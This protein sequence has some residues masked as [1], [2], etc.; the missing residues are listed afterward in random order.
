MYYD[1]IK[2]SV[3]VYFKEGTFRS[4][5]RNYIVGPGAMAKA[6]I[7]SK[8]RTAKSRAGRSTPAKRRTTKT[9]SKATTTRKASNSHVSV[10][11][12]HGMGSQRRHEELSRLVDSL[13]IF[14]DDLPRIRGGPNEMLRA[15]KPCIEPSRVP[16]AGDVTYV[17]L[18]YI[19]LTGAGAPSGDFRFYEAY[20][21][22]V[23][24]DYSAWWQVF[25][26]M[27]RRVF[28]PVQTAFSRWRD[29]Q[30]LR[31]AALLGL[32]DRRRGWPEGCATSD[33]KQLLDAYHDFEGP[34]ARRDY[35]RGRFRDFIAFLEARHKSDPDRLA[36]LHLLAKK[37]RRAYASSE[38]SNAFFLFTLALG[39]VMGIAV[40]AGLVMLLL[41]SISPLPIVEKLVGEGFG[42]LANF[43]EPTWTNVFSLLVSLAGLLGLTRFLSKYMGDVELWTTYEETNTKHKNRREVIKLGAG[44]LRHVL[45]DPECR[46]VV[47][48][49]HSLGTSVAQD[50]LL[51]LTR[52]NLA[53]NKSNPIAGPIPLEK[54]RHFVTL[55]SPI[56]KVQYFFES[57]TS[58]HHRYNRVVEELRGDIGGP[59]F[60]KNG[61]PHIHWVNYWDR[62]D[63]IS[64]SLESPSNSEKSTLRVDN[65]HT[66]N[67][68]F[69]DPGASHSAYFQNRRVIGHLFDMIFRNKYSFANVPR[70]AR[71]APICSRAFIGP[72]VYHARP[73]YLLALATTLPYLALFCALPT[74][75]PVLAGL[76]PILPV[77]SQWA[78]L[79]AS[80]SF[81]ILV[82][83]SVF[84]G[85]GYL[86]GR[87]LGHRDPL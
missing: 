29:R 12:F 80:W 54:I 35:P 28:R 25:K 15:I 55:A 86:A 62:A 42:A 19:N 51:S 84:L 59:P 79:I 50:C 83:V 18:R 8:R 10:V 14:T 68:Y 2:N 61:K 76:I 11:Y 44:V 3:G 60:A 40:S 33:F 30:R 31:R 52:H 78:D 39:L 67:L 24:A 23:M 82:A 27:W 85:L 37:W 56:D 4:K 64:G 43:V 9:K 16:K 46:R 58:D 49:S 87:S 21:A 66:S 34:E 73:I 1:P 53:R 74:I 41:E 17:E 72:G 6:A 45:E 77:T 65:V 38:T 71:R 20:W 47:V 81:A 22:P 7:K 32:R 48:V 13:D 26:W 69:P 5:T 57:Y 36:I 63:I 70:N 75:Y